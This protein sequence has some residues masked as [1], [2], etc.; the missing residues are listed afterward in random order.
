MTNQSTTFDYVVAGGG[1]AGCIVARRLADA[2]HRVCLIEAGPAD[3]GLPEVLAMDRWD[4]LLEGPLDWGYRIAPQ[5]LGNDNVVQS[6]GRVLGGSSSHNTLIAF[7]M[8]DADLDAWV[9]RGARGWGPREVEHLFDR[10]EAQ[11]AIERHSSGDRYSDAF[12]EAC[13]QAGL[14]TESFARNPGH[15]DSAGWLQLNAR[16]GVRQSTSVAYLHP[17]AELPANLVVMTDTPVLRVLIESG[18]AVGV[19][20]ANG[21][22][23]AGRE[24]VLAGGVFGSTQMLLLSGIGPADHLRAVG[25]SVRH[26]LPGVGEHLIDHV[27][28]VI[29]WRTKA[30]DLPRLRANYSDTAVFKRLDPASPLPDIM[31]HFCI[32]PYEA[33]TTAMG[34]PTVDHGFSICPNVAHARSEGTVRLRSADPADT[35]DVDPR[36]FSDPEGYDRRVIVEGH[37]FAR[38]IAAQPALARL[39]DSEWLPGPEAA[40]DEALWQ[41]ARRTT[42]TT[43]HPAGTCRMGAVDDPLAVV[44][45]ELRVRGIAGL[46]VADGA[47]FPSMIGVNLCI[48]TMMIGEK[49]AELI[50]GG[51]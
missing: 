40:D 8:P 39:I 25:V 41:F 11:V 22:V 4:E 5:K 37:K 48:P 47:V 10:I 28:G 15:I 31:A 14:P 9:A 19:E 45:P 35:L 49:A 1:T 21:P 13:A 32:P 7:R 42:N 33:M 16:D 12:L 24:V 38:E 51:D 6:R 30:D 27:E 50:L 36:Y 20:T 46:R 3:E 18:R 34:M 23:R 44:D 29:T 2:G 26:D 43:Y 17:L